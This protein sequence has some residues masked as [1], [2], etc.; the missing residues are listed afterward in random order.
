MGDVYF[1]GMYPFVHVP[2]GGS[3]EG[4]I[5]TVDLV[6]ERI[7]DKTKVIPGHGP[8]SNKAGLQAYRDMLVGVHERAKRLIGCS[9]HCS[10]DTHD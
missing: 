8:L 6:L 4:V 3:I 2:G 9:E 7:D 10:S 5:R 1:A